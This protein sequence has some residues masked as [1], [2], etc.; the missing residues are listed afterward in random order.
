MW[1][2]WNFCSLAAIFLATAVLAQ[3]PMAIKALRAA[4]RQASI[5]EI[6]F[7]TTEALAVDAEIRVV[8]PAAYDLSG[9][10]IAGSTTINGGLTMTRDG[11]RVVVKR[12]GLGTVVPSGQRVSLQLGL[13]RNPSS[14]AA[15]E[16]VRVEVLHSK[17]AT[18]AKAFA[19]SV[20]FQSR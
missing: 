5:Y 17:K 14:F 3:E 15:A 1:K 16:Q 10:E 18:A 7:S 13:I 4:P 8:F 2:F 12:T 11:Q 6:S 20:E 19:S 9:L